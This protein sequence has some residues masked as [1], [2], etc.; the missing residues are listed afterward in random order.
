MN[1]GSLGS[2]AF[3]QDHGIA[4]AY[5]A[6]SM[7]RGIAS[8]HLVVAMARAGFLSFLGAAGMAPDRVAGEIAAIRRELGPDRAFGVNLLSDL[9]DPAREM[10]RV[11]LLLGQGVRLIEASAFVQPTPALV[12]FHLRGLRRAPDGRVARDTRIIA[13]LSRPEVAS[14]LL[15]PAPEPMVAQLLA[16]GKVTAEQAELAREVPL[17]QD[18]CVEADSGGHTDRGVSTV[19]LPAIQALRD[20]RSTRFP[21][22][23]RAR[24]GLAGGIG[25]PQAV[26]AAFVMGADFVTTGSI[27]QCTVE[28]GISDAVKDRLQQINVQDT[29]YCPAG[30][31]FEMGALVQVLRKGVLFPARA[32]KLFALYQAHESWDDIP[33]TTRAQIERTFFRKSA[34]E[35]WQETAAYLQRTGR[36]A[37]AGRAARSPKRRMALMFRWYYG[38][39]SRLSLTEPERDLANVQ[40]HT[41]PALGA[42]NQW[43]K[44]TALHDWRCRHV[45]DIATRLMSEGAA[46]LSRQ[47]RTAT[48]SKEEVS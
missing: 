2:A 21:A 28:S 33:A 4:Y 29:A 30:D 3:R 16:A 32:N 12:L 34:D 11:E 18:L 5:A 38:Y 1:P 47:A 40:V 6:G 41:G 27:N 19:L 31:L 39:S 8:R 37:E 44:G 10:A 36:A 48:A 14:A 24:V 42:F 20:E 45:D 26:A 7:Y 46:L 15:D 23:Q 22:A 9:Q 43:V 35:V 13:K 25:T 17:C